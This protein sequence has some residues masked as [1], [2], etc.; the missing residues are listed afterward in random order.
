MVEGEGFMEMVKLMEPEYT[1]PCRKHFVKLLQD[2]VLVGVTKLKKIL[3][4]DVEK[5]AIT[6]DIW[7][8]LTN[9]PY[10]SQCALHQ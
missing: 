9:E 10:M 4:D 6:T 3:R 7:T 1:I 5:F 2:K 8:S